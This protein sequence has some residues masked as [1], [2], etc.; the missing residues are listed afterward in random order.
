M[1]D[2][3]SVVKSLILVVSVHNVRTQCTVSV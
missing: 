3:A 1:N 2:Y